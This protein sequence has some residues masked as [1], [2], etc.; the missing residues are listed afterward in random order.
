MRDGRQFDA[1]AFALLIVRRLVVHPQRAQ[2]ATQIG[3]EASAETRERLVIAVLAVQASAA[4][5]SGRHRRLVVIHVV[6]IAASRRR[7]EPERRRR[8]RRG[9]SVQ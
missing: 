5:L 4:E 2:T 1:V 3:P 7:P 8:R 6:A 9:Q